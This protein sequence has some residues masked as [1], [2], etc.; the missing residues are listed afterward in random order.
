LYLAQSA[1]G[2]TK[3]WPNPKPRCAC[4]LLLP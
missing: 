2:Q 1:I 4:L 3:R